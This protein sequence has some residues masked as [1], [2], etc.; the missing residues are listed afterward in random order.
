MFQAWTDDAAGEAIDEASGQDRR[1][2]RL[3]GKIEE[4]AKE[5]R[6]GCKGW[7]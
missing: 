3:K 1:Q 4:T 6:G 5:D 7:D 2:I